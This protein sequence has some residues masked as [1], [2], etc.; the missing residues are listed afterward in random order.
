MVTGCK[1][2]LY[3]SLKHKRVSESVALRSSVARC[4]KQILR[5]SAITQSYSPPP[6]LTYTL[7]QERKCTEHFFSFSIF[8]I[9]SQQQDTLTWDTKLHVSSEHILN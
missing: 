3:L 1:Y 7:Q 2:R 8:V 5:Q 6:P 4:T 9:I